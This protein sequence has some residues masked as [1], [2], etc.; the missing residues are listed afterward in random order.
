MGEVISKMPNGDYNIVDGSNMLGDD[1]HR[2]ISASDSTIDES[3][4]K[5]YY[6]T[7]MKMDW[8]G[9]QIHLGDDVIEH[10]WVKEVWDKVNPEMRLLKH[11]LNGH[12]KGLSNTMN[13]GAEI[14]NQYTVIVYLTPDWQPED[15]G[16]VEFWTPNL[17]K[18]MRAVA[19]KTPYG[20]QGS[21]AINIVKSYWPRSGRVILFDSRI[22]HV[23]R[24]V[25]SDKFRVS[26]VFKGTTDP[27]KEDKQD[28]DTSKDPFKGTDI[29]GKD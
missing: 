7:A 1:Y 20:L 5:K 10:D 13:H 22:P 14:A 8:L 18:Q 3:D 4:I 2:T 29:E 6:D 12:G 19:V 11:Y 26:L 21:D 25:E 17:T 16:S 23:E 24:S 15:G 27:I 28:K 9:E